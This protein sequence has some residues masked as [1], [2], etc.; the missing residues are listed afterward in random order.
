MIE[1]ISKR[2]LKLIFKNRLLFFVFLIG[3]FAS[4][5]LTYGEI[6]TLKGDIADYYLKTLLKEISPRGSGIYNY[7][8]ES[9][10]KNFEEIVKLIKDGNEESIEEAL[11]KAQKIGYEIFK[12][13]QL[14]T[15]DN[16]LILKEKNTDNRKGWGSY[17][18]NFDSENNII[19]ESP[20]PLNHLQ[21]GFISVTAFKKLNAKALLLPGAH[22]LSSSI[23][24]DGIP[25]SDVGFSKESIFNTVHQILA[26][27]RKIIVQFQ[28][29]SN[30][31][32][33]NKKLPPIILTNGDTKNFEF[34]NILKRNLNNLTLDIEKEK[35]TLNACLYGEDGAIEKNFSGSDNIQGR[36]IRQQEEKAKNYFTIIYMDR[37][38]RTHNGFNPENEKSF[39]DI[40]KIIE[41]IE[42]SVIDFEITEDKIV[43]GVYEDLKETAPVVIQED[44][45]VIKEDV[46]L[47]SFFVEKS[48]ISKDVSTIDFIGK[49]LLKDVTLLITVFIA[50][51]IVLLAVSIFAFITAF[52]YKA[53][54]KNANNRIKKLESYRD[55]IEDEFK[56][57]IQLKDEIENNYK[58]EKQRSE[59]IEKDFNSERKDKEHFYDGYNRLVAEK[60]D[61]EKKLDKLEKEFKK[62]K[63]RLSFDIEYIKS[64]EKGMPDTL[65]ELHQNFDELIVENKILKDNLRMYKL[66]R[67][68]S[69]KDV[70]NKVTYILI[71]GELKLKHTLKNL[72]N[73]VSNE[74]DERV[75]IVAVWALGE[76]GEKDGV[77]ILLNII[78]SKNKDTYRYCKNA[79]KKIG[80]MSEDGQ[81]LPE[82]L[83]ES[84]KN[85]IYK[86]SGFSSKERFIEYVLDNDDEDIRI[87]GIK[88]LKKYGIENY[89]PII[90]EVIEDESPEVRYEAIEVISNVKFI[91]DSTLLIDLDRK[92]KISE[93]LYN[94][95]KNDSSILIRRIAAKTL[96]K[97]YS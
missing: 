78:N 12:F 90:L 56:N 57:V 28:G 3:L 88:I 17:I 42:K 24:K 70:K 19:V 38:I 10:I 67:L 41:S 5:T 92:R 65:P 59:K 7:P 26:D 32:N 45:S 23:K 16:Y 40:I 27:E 94:L 63:N 25:V 81:F 60:W 50:I 43:P 48:E 71:A 47:E 58:N 93:V 72:F 85:D 75:F 13:H 35:T 2:P 74:N 77:N 15:D 69:D 39:S 22:R 46:D 61:L 4:R 21:T 14:E 30:V 96:D 53:D 31:R 97:F 8:A 29:Y 95:L 82:G 55:N 68:M 34:L 80:Y 91:K 73:I 18:L 52:K 36:F 1:K 76:I 9:D 44:T 11:P 87:L 79:L 64:K 86:Y 51:T 84:N 62:E 6:N 33:V 20:Y 37:G 54:T 49:E 83:S 66:I 89:I